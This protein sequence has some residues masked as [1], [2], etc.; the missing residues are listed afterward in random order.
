MGYASITSVARRDKPERPMAMNLACADRGSVGGHER[1]CSSVC[2]LFGHTS[3]QCAHCGNKACSKMPEKFFDLADVFIMSEDLASSRAYFTNF[4]FPLTDEYKNKMAMFTYNATASQ[5][6]QLIDDARS[7][8]FSKFWVTEKGMEDGVPS[9]FEE[10]VE[11][12][13]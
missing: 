7:Q 2:T 9:W 8:G 11:Y 1:A 4:S 6:R 10:M 3:Y 5:W 12:I 13:R